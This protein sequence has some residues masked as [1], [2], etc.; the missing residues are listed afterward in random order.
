MGSYYWACYEC[1]AS[2]S[3]RVQRCRA[4]GYVRPESLTPPPSS[5]S[6]ATE[7]KPEH[8]S[9]ETAASGEAK[10]PLS[11][12]T[13]WADDNPFVILAI[14]AVLIAPLVLMFL[15]LNASSALGLWFAALAIGIGIWVYWYSGRSFE[16]DFERLREEWR[17]T[18]APRPAPGPAVPDTTVQPARSPKPPT[19]VPRSDLALTL[20]C[21]DCA[22]DVGVGA[23][24]CPYCGHRLIAAWLAYCETCD[25]RVEATASGHCPA[26]GT[27]VAD[28]RGATSK[29][30]QAVEDLR[31]LMAEFTTLM[32]A[33][34]DALMHKWT[35]AFDTEDLAMIHS[36][37]AATMPTLEA[38]KSMLDDKRAELLR[39][40]PLDG[41]TSYSLAIDFYIDAGNDWLAGDLDGATAAMGIGQRYWEQAADVLEAALDG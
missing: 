30:G 32:V 35:S 26:C 19:S 27:Q 8:A 34:D 4:C 25:R 20:R 14:A 3:I 37:I 5:A 36:V 1:G 38:M 18:T 41:F 16:E 2:N 39:I 12:L 24:S 40:V 29:G 11:R 17:R 23:T 31:Q 10:D 7:S 13:R 6:A 15:G 22:E 9:M 21:P 33:V 28:A